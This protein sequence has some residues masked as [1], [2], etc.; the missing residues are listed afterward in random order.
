M[1]VKTDAI[2]LRARKFRETSRILTLYTREFGKLSAI[3]K[4]ARGAKGRFGASLQP[5]THVTAVLYKHDH[6]ELQLLSQCDAL[7]DVRSLSDDLERF[8]VA[9]AIIEMVDVV[10]HDEERNVPLYELLLGSLTS[11]GSAERHA[12]N[13]QFYFDIHLAGILGFRPNFH[14]CLAC[15]AELTTGGIGTKGGELRL[16]NGG[17]LCNVCSDGA[18]GQGSVTQGSLKLLQHLQDAQQPEDATRLKL[19]EHQ[20]E[21][22]SSILR[23][24][25]ESHV[26]GLHRLKARSL[27]QSIIKG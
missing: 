2:V 22:I 21:E 6:R 14:T 20:T 15:G 5:A 25:L 24:Y 10:S 19:T 7:T 12:L 26:G 11:V 4:G 18:Q 23:H 27:A 9:M 8:T 1:I 17:V 3:A 13:I 16:G